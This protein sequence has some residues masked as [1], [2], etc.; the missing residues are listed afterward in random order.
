MT[1]ILSSLFP[2]FIHRPDERKAGTA[3]SLVC[4]IND[5]LTCLVWTEYVYKILPYPVNR[6]KRPKTPGQ[7]EVRATNLA[8]VRPSQ[9]K[10]LYRLLRSGASL[11]GGIEQL[12]RIGMDADL[13]HTIAVSNHFMEGNRGIGPMRI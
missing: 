3:S 11:G 1:L 4:S 9:P 5:R 8:F 10:Q 12:P 7:H 13:R 2:S 6:N